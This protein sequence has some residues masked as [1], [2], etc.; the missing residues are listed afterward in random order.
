M[1]EAKENKNLPKNGSTLSESMHLYVLTKVLERGNS[2]LSQIFSA[3]E[4]IEIIEAKLQTYLKIAKDH[5]NLG[6]FLPK[7]SLNA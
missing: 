2:K 3:S 5:P 6:G 1:P 7:L 4:V